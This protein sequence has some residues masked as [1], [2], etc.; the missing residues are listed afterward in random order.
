[1]EGEIQKFDTENGGDIEKRLTRW[2]TKLGWY[3]T[4]K[5]IKVD[6]LKKTSL[7]FFGGDG[8]VDIYEEDADDGDN[9]DAI[10]KKLDARLIPKQNNQLNRLNFRKIVQYDDEPF[11]EFV[12]RLRDKGKIGDFADL[13]QEILSQII[14]GCL[15]IDLKKQA[16]SSKDIT[17]DRSK[18]QRSEQ[19]QRSGRQLGQPPNDLNKILQAIEELKASK[20]NTNECDQT[21]TSTCWRIQEESS[22]DDNVCRPRI[23]LPICGEK[24]TFLI[25]TGC[26][27]YNVMDEQ[28][29]KSINVDRRPILNR[30]FTNIFAY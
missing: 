10:I 19:Q 30:N 22:K 4:L 15:S 26:P 6:E 3:F 1:M 21:G 23:N 16:L 25:D 8:I 7:F 28:T 20:S 27:K 9:Y 11:S 29:F 2:K 18:K 17:L 24:V 13:K 14:N 5:N 12:Q